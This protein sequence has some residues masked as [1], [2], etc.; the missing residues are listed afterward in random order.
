MAMR[1]EIAPVVTGMV[2]ETLRTTPNGAGFGR[3]AMDGALEDSPRQMALRTVRSCLAEDAVGGR[4]AGAAH[5]LSLGSPQTIPGRL[6]GQGSA[7]AWRR[8]PG[9]ASPSTS[10]QPFG[11]TSSTRISARPATACLSRLEAGADVDYGHGEQAEAAA[12]DA[13]REVRDLRVG[14]D[15]AGRSPTCRCARTRT[16]FVAYETLA[17]GRRRTT[18]IELEVRE[19][20]RSPQLGDGPGLATLRLLSCVVPCCGHHYSS[21]ARFTAVRSV[22]D[23][24]D[25]PRTRRG[26]VLGTHVTQVS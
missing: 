26:R 8:P 5:W 22:R 10:P 18:K 3:R 24:T 7:V 19:S 12:V 4:S 20:S 13:E 14:A 1:G 6:G 16:R 11:S 2:T 9:T 23:I 21:G 15:R 25:R 17:S